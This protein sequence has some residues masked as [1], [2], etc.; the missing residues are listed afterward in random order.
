MM[1]VYIFKDEEKDLK[2]SRGNDQVSL[3]SLRKQSQATAKFPLWER[4]NYVALAT[5]ER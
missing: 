1:T 5:G 2:F 4:G 3:E